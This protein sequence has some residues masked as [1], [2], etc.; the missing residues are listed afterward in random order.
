MYMIVIYLVN[1]KVGILH[2]AILF[3]NKHV[4]NVFILLKSCIQLDDINIDHKIVY[5]SAYLKIE[6]IIKYRI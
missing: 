1:L 6:P 4:Q 5:N 3:C 2:L